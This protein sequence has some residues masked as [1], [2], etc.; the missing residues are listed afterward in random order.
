MPPTL[1]LLHL[2]Y[3]VL[4]TP[5]GTR[6]RIVIDVTALDPDTDAPLPLLT[7]ALL[8][9]LADIATDAMADAARVTPPDPLS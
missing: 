1:A 2:R 7:G 8:D 3:T 6:G 9:K 4:H 5:D